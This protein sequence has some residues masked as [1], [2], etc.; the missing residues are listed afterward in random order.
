MINGI[1]CVKP[2][3]ENCKRCTVG[4]CKL[5]PIVIAAKGIPF[6]GSACCS[7]TADAKEAVLK[8][9]LGIKSLPDAELLARLEELYWIGFKAGSEQI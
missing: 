7:A 1:G 4:Y 5:S 2:V 9:V 3:E 8:V 6:A